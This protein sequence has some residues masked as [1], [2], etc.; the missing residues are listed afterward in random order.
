MRRL[1]SRDSF[2]R[3]YVKVNT[4]IVANRIHFIFSLFFCVFVL[5]LAA[6]AFHRERGMIGEKTCKKR[7]SKPL[8]FG[9]RRK[10]IVG[11]AADVILLYFF[12]V[13]RAFST[14]KKEANQHAKKRIRKTKPKSDEKGFL[15]LL[16]TCS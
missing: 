12:G 6:L 4:H 11:F 16:L 9:R 2:P 14:L 1:C 10:A 8:S 3:T 13:R 15:V 5:F 7:K